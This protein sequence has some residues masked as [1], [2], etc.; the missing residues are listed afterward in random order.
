MFP[1]PTNTKIQ[2]AISVSTL[3]YYYVEFSH[4]DIALLTL[5]SL[6]KEVTDK[7]VIDGDKLKL[8]SVSTVFED[9]IG[10]TVVSK[11][12]CMTPTSKHISVKYHWFRQHAGKEFLIRKIE[13]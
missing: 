5:M 2:T 11:S 10:A 1:L 8:V 4:S 6:I 13:S 7:L 12:P 9:N 3:H